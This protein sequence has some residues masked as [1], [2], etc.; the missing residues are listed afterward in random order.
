MHWPARVSATG[1]AKKSCSVAV[2]FTLRRACLSLSGKACISR[3][4]GNSDTTGNRVRLQVDEIQ[5]HLAFSKDCGEFPPNARRAI[6]SGMALL[7]LHRPTGLL[8]LRAVVVST[9][10]AA[11]PSNRFTLV[12]AALWRILLPE[13]CCSCGLLDFSAYLIITG[14]RYIAIL[15]PFF[16]AFIISSLQMSSHKESIV[17]WRIDEDFSQKP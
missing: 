11:V 15:M 3:L 2:S 1:T 16:H 13:G 9:A 7:V 12:W 17:S 4:L 14:T 6:P 5:P 10:P 8:K